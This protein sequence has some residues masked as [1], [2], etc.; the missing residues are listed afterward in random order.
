MK[1]VMCVN[2]WKPILN[3]VAGR[4]SMNMSMS[5]CAQDL[6]SMQKDLIKE[7][8]LPVYCGLNTARCCTHTRLP[9]VP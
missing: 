2:L 7:Q 3:I 5:L 1:N 4:F 6:L 9:N 8:V